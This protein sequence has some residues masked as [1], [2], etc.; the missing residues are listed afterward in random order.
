M[1]LNNKAEK[2]GLTKL[3]EISNSSVVRIWG[4]HRKRQ[5][6]SCNT[7]LMLGNR[8]HVYAFSHLPPSLIKMRFEHHL[9]TGI[10]L[11]KFWRIEDSAVNSRFRTFVRPEITVM[12][13]EYKFFSV[14]TEIKYG[15][16]LNSH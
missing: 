1:K 4:K 7:L 13:K 6:L 10:D 2:S 15:T 9:L 5:F 11:A 14:D 3:R 16:N 12:H 8:I